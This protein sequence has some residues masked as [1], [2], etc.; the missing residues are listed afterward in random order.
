MK[1][2]PICSIILLFIFSAE[3]CY[4]HA[5]VKKCSLIIINQRGERVPLSVEIAQN[6][7]RRRK[8]LMFR[9]RLPINEGMLFVFETEQRLNFWMRN[10]YIPLSIA[11]ID[12]CGVVR[13]ILEM[14]PLDDSK[15]Y[16]SKYPAKY[17]LE[18]N[19]GWFA[20]RG[21]TPGSRIIFDGCIGK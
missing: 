13:E 11:Y 3:T 16:P 12:G 5:E 20:S 19:M 18:V 14:S 9:K 7:F 6:E 10:T 15:T 1:I 2:F 17:A 21:I 4:L 8:G